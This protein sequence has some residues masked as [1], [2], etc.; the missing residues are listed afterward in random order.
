MVV[1]FVIAP[2]RRP[3]IGTVSWR[4]SGGES[5]R[6]QAQDGNLGQHRGTDE[7]Q[8]IEQGCITSICERQ[9]SETVARES[10]Q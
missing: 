4:I 7:V 9:D 6:R 10:Q 2:G 5:N 1:W 8:T 3:S